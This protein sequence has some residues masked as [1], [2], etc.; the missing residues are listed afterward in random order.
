MIAELPLFLKK[1]ASFPIEKLGNVR[2]QAELIQVLQ[3]TRYEK[4]L[5]RAI[6]SGKLNP[7]YFEQLLKSNYYEQLLAFT[8]QM[9]KDGKE[10]VK[11]VRWEI[12]TEN[13]IL[14]YRLKVY[15]DYQPQQILP[16]LM[17]VSGQNDI[18]RLQNLLATNSKE[19]L[20]RCF[21]KQYCSGAEMPPGDY[22][23]G[24]A[25]RE[26][27][28]VSRHNLAFS[29]N[30][31]VAFYCYTRLAK[32]EVEDIITILEGIRYQVSPERLKP[33][34]AIGETG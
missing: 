6:V 1:H 13:F 32:A 14:A 11:M 8:K 12:E 18:A 7:V 17:S 15:F 22:I 25:K 27:C 24:P 34:L 30:P 9:G 4:I 33:L 2:T 26:R 23:E 19:Q 29:N 3:K 28:V 10:L 5:S 20:Q 31:A 16:H 21:L